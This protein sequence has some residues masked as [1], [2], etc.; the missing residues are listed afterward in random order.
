[1]EGEAPRGRKKI[2]QTSAAPPTRVGVEPLL[3]IHTCGGGA[4]VQHSEPRAVEEEARHAQP[5]L[6]A[7]GGGQRGGR[8]GF[9]KGGFGGGREAGL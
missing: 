1:M 6:L 2:K 4:L 8:G 9:S 3:H 5:L 7:C